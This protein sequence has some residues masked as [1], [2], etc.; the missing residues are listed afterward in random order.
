MKKFVCIVIL[1][2][3]TTA[4][5]QAVA[6]YAPTPSPDPMTLALSG[7]FTQLA[8]LPVPDADGWLPWLHPY[9]AHAV[10][11]DVDGAGTRG[12][13]ASKMTTD[14]AQYASGA[15][16]PG[17]IFVQRLF[18]E[19]EG[20]VL[21]IELADSPGVTAYGRLVLL[22]R[23]DIAA[24]SVIAYTLLAFSHGE[25]VGVQSMGTA[26]YRV[27][28]GYTHQD[29]PALNRY[30]IND[31]TGH[32]WDR[33]W[34]NDR[35][36]THEE[37]H[38][39]K[40]QYGLHE[41]ASP[42]WT[43]PNEKQALLPDWGIRMAAVPSNGTGVQVLVHNNSGRRLFYGDRFRVPGTAIDRAHTWAGHSAIE[44]GQS[45][46]LFMDF[47]QTL[48]AGLYTLR[49]N[50]YTD[51]ALTKLYLIATA[52][53][54]VLCALPATPELEA[55][56]HQHQQAE[57]A[58]IL[59]IGPSTRITLTEPPAVSRTAIAFTTINQSSI[60]FTHGAQFRLFHYENGWQP[61]LHEP[62]RF[63][64]IARI[65]RPRQPVRHEIPLAQLPPGRYLLLRRHTE[66]NVPLTAP[67]RIEMVMVEFEISDETS[68]TL[69]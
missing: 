36:L 26:I 53:F 29:A 17:D 50:F 58:L 27:W 49:R 41:I 39:F 20:E 62:T 1:L 45:H 57:M 14:R 16:H 52:D 44:P 5:G 25:I 54:V 46:W 67:Q 43:L 42:V 30:F 51:P 40:A 47:Y 63:S 3:L 69:Q 18:I 55:A 6:D 66:D 64:S 8:P 9:N 60:P 24:Q 23:A 33:D 2:F 48:P 32:F 59:A 12:V 31:H 10:W 61:T 28:D 15:M 13:L 68:T 11:V 38:A 37:A 56:I 7:F 21:A 34:E 19:Y 22:P 35:T 4:C 65:D